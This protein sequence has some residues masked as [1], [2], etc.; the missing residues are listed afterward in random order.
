MT[1][2]CN[3]CKKNINPS[4][5]TYHCVACDCH[6]HLTRV[7]TGLTQV[8]VNGIAELG[9]NAMLLCNKCEEKNECETFI[10]CRTSDKLEEQFEQF[11]FEAKMEQLRTSLTKLIETKVAE[12][13]KTTSANVEDTY[14]KVVARSI[15]KKNETSNSENDNK[16]DN[17]NIKKSFRI[18]GTL[19]DVEKSHGE[20]LVPTTEKVNDVLKTI[21]VQPQIVGM[22]RLGK[23]SS[24]AKP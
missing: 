12:A 20:N 6:L 19:E 22:K 9:M 4:D 21:C 10:R 23:F 2:N 16:Y 17:H 15:P 3:T 24:G 11:N 14:A 18:Q 7:C 1:R 13:M 5:K 8:A